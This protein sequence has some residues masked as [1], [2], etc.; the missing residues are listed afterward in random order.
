MQ[1]R[2]ALLGINRR[3]PWSIKYL[4]PQCRGIQGQGGRE[5]G[6]GR[7]TTSQKQEGRWNT[8]FLGVAEARKVI[9]FEM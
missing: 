7:G 4:I 5:E 3:D 2:M 9:T 1:Q 6:V 8:E